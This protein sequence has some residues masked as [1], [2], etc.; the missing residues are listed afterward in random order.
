MIVSAALWQKLSPGPSMFLSSC[1]AQREAAESSW[2]EAGGVERG[3]IF[4]T[5]NSVQSPRSCILFLVSV[6]K[7]FFE[8]VLLYVSLTGLEL[9]MYQ[10]GLELTEI[11]CLCLSDGEIKGMCP[12]AMG[13]YCQFKPLCCSVFEWE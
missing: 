11:V 7:S 1:T 6:G 9:A 10:A 8:V 3:L 13:T 2:E 4:M 5:W 12:H